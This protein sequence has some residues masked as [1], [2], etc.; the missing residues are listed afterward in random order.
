ME[1]LGKLPLGVLLISQEEKEKLKIL[2]EYAM[3]HVVPWKDLISRKPIGNEP[4]HVVIIPADYRVVF[5]IEE[6]REPIGLSRH[7]SVSVSREDRAPRPESI[8]IIAKELGFRNNIVE[9]L[10]RYKDKVIFHADE[11]LM[12]GRA[13]LWTENFSKNRI[14]INF[15]E[16]INIQYS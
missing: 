12:G 4:K 14:A 10:G 16:K 7:L 6:Q 5:S 11:E 3:A 1:V 15:L 9:I 8:Q 13:L 2:K